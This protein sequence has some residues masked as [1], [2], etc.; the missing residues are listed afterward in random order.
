MTNSQ[1][2]DSA[3]DFGNNEET[4]L[5]CFSMIEIILKEARKI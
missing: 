5:I 3:Q 2:W 4:H 1:M